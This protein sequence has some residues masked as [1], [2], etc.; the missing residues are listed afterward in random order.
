MK[1]FYRTNKF[2]SIAEGSKAFQQYKA[3]LKE[4]DLEKVKKTAEDINKQREKQASIYTIPEF[5]YKDFNSFL[6][7]L[8]KDDPKI[9]LK[10][11]MD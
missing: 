4:E 5:Q 8:R 6:R 1:E 10:K 9:P 3:N 2:P 11:D 7:N